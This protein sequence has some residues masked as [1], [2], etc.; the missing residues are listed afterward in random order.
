MWRTI[1]HD[2]AIDTDVPP[3]RITRHPDLRSTSPGQ[4]AVSVQK[5][6]E[7]AMTFGY[8]DFQ[9]NLYRAAALLVGGAFL[10]PDLGNFT[11]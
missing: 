4:N 8:L 7:K 6:N 1:L 3:I 2:M 9:I 11:R 5:E 10:P